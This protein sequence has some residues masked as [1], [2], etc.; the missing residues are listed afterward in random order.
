[1][2]SFEVEFIG[3]DIMILVYS[4]FPIYEREPKYKF[5][6]F[7]VNSTFNHQSENAIVKGLSI[8]LIMT[9]SPSMP[10]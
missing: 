9:E 2:V 10:K 1:M 8:Q 5:Y 4:Y 3:K 7:F 6:K